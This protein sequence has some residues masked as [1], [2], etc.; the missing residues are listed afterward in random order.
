[1]HESE[2]I[3]QTLKDASQGLLYM[4]ESDY[5]FEVIYITVDHN[6]PLAADT[7]PAYLDIPADALI[8]QTELEHFL[9]HMTHP[10]DPHD[11]V[12]MEEAPKFRKLEKTLRET[13]E[14]L[15]VYR[16]GEIQIEAYILGY[17]KEGNI[18]G[19]RTTLIET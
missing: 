19:L 4:S 18:A 15:Q 14:K 9:K 11:E 17:T 13:L 7:L 8:E 2:H 12:A 1:M 5:P 6:A 16:V 10:A 3:T